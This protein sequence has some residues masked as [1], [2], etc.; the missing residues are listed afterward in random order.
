MRTLTAQMEQS[1]ATVDEQEEKLRV[2]E[3]EL[4]K[5]TH[6]A[7]N[8]DAKISD[9]EEQN[10]ALKIEGNEL[11]KGEVSGNGIYFLKYNVTLCMCIY[12]YRNECLEEQS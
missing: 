9:L 4:I 10:T 11:N 8:K 1:K 5:M 3:G 6:A 2:K 12:C 7:S